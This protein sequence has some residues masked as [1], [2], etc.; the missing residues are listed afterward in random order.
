MLSLP[1]A[2]SSYFWGKLAGRLVVTV[3]PVL[4]GLVLA[5]GW[6]LAT[7]LEVP[8]LIMGYYAALL[9]ALA[10]CFLGF[11]MLISAAVRR[12]DWGLGLAL[13]VW[14]ACLLLL[15]L[16]LLG[17]LIRSHL[18][19]QLV[20]LLALLNPLQSFRVAAILLFDPELSVLGATAY[21]IQ[22]LFGTQG[23]LAYAVLYP[24]ALGAAVASMGY[25]L[26]RKGDLI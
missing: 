24:L 17:A 16:V 11:G 23:F 18:P 22:D 14:L 7:G 15:D 3:L 20:L 26:F 6:G 9:V 21:L 19:E 10:W 13:L 4:T 25:A 5:G 1:M 2:L 12:L 8:W